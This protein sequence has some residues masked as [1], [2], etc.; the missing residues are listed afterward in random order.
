MC[1]FTYKFGVELWFCLLELVL[2]MEEEADMLVIE[3][4]VVRFAAQPRI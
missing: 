2:G 1:S 4:R 3:V